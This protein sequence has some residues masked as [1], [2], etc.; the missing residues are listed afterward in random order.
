VVFAGKGGVGKTTTAA[1]TALQAGADGGKVLLVSADPS[2]SLADVL[3]IRLGPDPQAVAAGVWAVQTDPGATARRWWEWIRADLLEGLAQLG[4]DPVGP[5]DVTGL[6][7]VA[8]LMAVLGVHDQVRTGPWDLVVVDT[9]AAAQVFGQL[10]AA[11]TV[12]GLL[13]RLL[14]PERRIDRL[15]QGRIRAGRPGEAARAV[16]P[17][18]VLADRWSAE[19]E[20]VRSMLVAPDTSVRLV[21][22]AEPV[23]LAGTRR[24][25]TA[26]VMSGFH[27]DAVLV[28]RLAAAMPGEVGE[29]FGTTPVLAVPQLTPAPCGVRRLT[30]LGRNL[31]AAPVEPLERPSDPDRESL[32]IT[33]SEQGFDLALRIPLARREDIDLGR[34]GDELV[35]DVDGYRRVLALPGALRRCQVTGATLRAGTLSIAF[36]PDPAEV[37]ERWR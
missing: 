7:G 30:E 10:T 18:V 2:R 36:S 34:R 3:D 15:T 26:L 5:E 8:D 28:N 4:L 9:P 6:P 32:E 13:A 22:T 11:D 16:D 35:I 23:V 31:C 17:L 37:P 25:F 1:A 21:L 12:A 14:P 20:R 19:L 24:L 33:R 29:S 27:V